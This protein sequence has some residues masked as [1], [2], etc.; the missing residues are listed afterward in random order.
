MD[1][2]TTYTISDVAKAAGVSVST[3]SR[4]LNGKQDVAP[5]TRER[6]QQVIQEMGFAPHIQAKR[7]RAGKTRN[8]A[9]LF[10]LKSP[11]DQPYNALEVEFILG[12]AAAA[13]DQE[14]LFSLLTASVTEQSLLNFY[15]SSQVDGLVLMHIHTDDWRINL[16]RQTN[17]PF[18][19]I[20]HCAD[21]TGLNF[22]G[23]D[24]EAAVIAAFDHVVGLGH[25]RIGFLGLPAEMHQ[26][27]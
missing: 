2:L 25:L 23:L 8:I 4:T 10:P 3:V 21:N 9:L 17:Y 16:L 20:G 18:V 15:R 22:V 11:G 1:E 26:R 5:L 13:A 24:F 7:L 19:M 27:G 6:V 12:A 14:F